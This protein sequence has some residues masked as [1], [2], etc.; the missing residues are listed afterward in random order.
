MIWEIVRMDARGFGGLNVVYFYY[1]TE[2]CLL[3]GRGVFL[4]ECFHVG[5]CLERRTERLPRF[6]N[7]AAGQSVRLSYKTQEY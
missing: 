2:A 1:L 3:A 6:M 4:C 5:L 7:F